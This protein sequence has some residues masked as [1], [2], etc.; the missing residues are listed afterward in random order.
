MKKF[1]L[2]LIVCVFS[3]I[4]S[5]AQGIKTNF[6]EK[7][8]LTDIIGY[9]QHTFYA[10]ESVTIHAYKKKSG[11]YHFLIETEDYAT[12]INCCNIPFH[13]TEK[14]LK[15]LPNALNSDADVLL[16]EK[17]Q[18]VYQRQIKKER[19]ARLAKEKADAEVKA[20]Y[21]VK[22][23]NGQVKGKLSFT[24][25]WKLEDE[26][27]LHRLCDE[28]IVSIIG[29]S[30]VGNLHYYAVYS[31]EVVGSFHSTLPTHQTFDNYKDIEFNNLPSDSDPKVLLVLKEQSVIVDSLRAIESVE[32]DRKTEET[33]V[34]RIQE[35]KENQ[36][37][38]IDEIS[39]SSNSVG[40]IYVSLNIT[41]CANQTIKYVTFQGYFLNAVGDK[42]RNEIGGSTIWKVR[43][44]GP[45][46]P[47]PT[48]I[49][50]N[51]ERIQKCKASYDFDDLTFY[52]R[53]ANT[54]RLSSVTVEYT[55]GRK[56]TLSGAN[57][58]KHV[59]Y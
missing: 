8:V 57:L 2:V 6:S 30:K 35:Y 41:N 20:Q 53:S 25:R 10:G 43:G 14:E 40:G 1:V 29:Y 28:G 36:P 51:Y 16:K 50:N 32:E 3:F 15:K 22:A 48:T 31:D 17:Q 56:L 23:L 47:S 38:I 13:A 45:I 4:W 59:R 39:W 27:G 54:F 7:I 34:K 55:N 21:R 24:G 37:F 18:T 44:V 19:E 58:D 5:Y 11:K 46:G 9:P 52:S 26:N 12:I 42:C 33:I 49:D